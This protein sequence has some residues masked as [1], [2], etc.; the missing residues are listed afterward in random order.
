[1]QSPVVLSFRKRLSNRGYTRISI[2]RA[3][4]PFGRWDGSTYMVSAN[5]PLTNTRLTC[6]YNISQMFNA[7]R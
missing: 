6:R 4:D 1:M 5:D 2:V 3:C 7:L